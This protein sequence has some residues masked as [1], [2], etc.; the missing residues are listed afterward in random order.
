MLN[1]GYSAFGRRTVTAG[2]DESALPTL[3]LAGG[4]YD[5]DTGL[6]RFGARDYDSVVGR[7]TAK[8]PLRFAA[9]TTNFYTYADS[10]PINYGDPDGKMPVLVAA[11]AACAAGV[12][13][14]AASAALW[15]A[16]TIGAA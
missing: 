8:E 6:T 4:I 14:A 13:E 5:E 9:S 2:T 11:A 15:T 7:W 1:A 10:D 12:C 16:A 3:G